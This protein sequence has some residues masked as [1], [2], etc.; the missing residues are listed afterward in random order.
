M[1]VG[2]KSGG[3]GIRDH[4]KRDPVSPRLDGMKGTMNRRSRNVG[5]L[6]PEGRRMRG[7]S[8]VKLGEF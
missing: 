8:D 2:G 5:G 4:T 6:I 3:G 7:D 1:S